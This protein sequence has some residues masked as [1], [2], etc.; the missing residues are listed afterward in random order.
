MNKSSLFFGGLFFLLFLLHSASV[1]VFASASFVPQFL[2]LFVIVFAATHS[3]PETLWFSFGAGFLWETFSAEFFGAQIFALIFCG[4]GA[5][6]VTRNIT[7]QELA[8]P[9][10][11]FLVVGATVLRPLLV[12]GYHAVASSLDLTSPIPFGTFL[13]PGVIYAALA[14][15]LVFYLLRFLIRLF[16]QLSK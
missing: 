13:N 1:K 9:T 4:L 16:P 3:L 12:A 15:L 2:L 6:L 7:A 8:A 11:A 5:Y 10:A 14:N